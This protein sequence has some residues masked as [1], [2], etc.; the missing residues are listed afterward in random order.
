[1]IVEAILSPIFYLINAF[2]GILPSF[3]LPASFTG[4]MTIFF[5]LLKGAS[6]FLPLGTIAIILGLVLSFYV[7]KFTIS[8]VNWVLGKIPTIN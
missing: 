1:M 5:D 2:L 6:Y 7:L 3:E 8:V 4:S